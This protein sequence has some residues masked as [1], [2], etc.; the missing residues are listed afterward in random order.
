MSVE[1]WLSPIISAVLAFVGGWVLGRQT[2][3]RE[4]RQHKS[5]RTQRYSDKAVEG[6][7]RARLIMGSFNPDSLIVEGEPGQSSN[8]IT[9]A[10]NNYQDARL[11]LTEVALG[12]PTEAVREAVA[13]A[14]DDAFKLMNA[15]AMFVLS[16]SPD[17]RE[18]MHSRIVEIRNDALEAFDAFQASLDDALAL[19]RNESEEKVQ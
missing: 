5:E 7:A 8:R 12:H 4:E 10:M 19:L 3:K 17:Y 9:E 16:F 11:P 6:L 14:D 18:A 2:E 15:T 1:V 13:K